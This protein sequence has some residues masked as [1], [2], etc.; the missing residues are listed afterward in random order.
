MIWSLDFSEILARNNIRYVLFSRY[1]SILFGNN[2][3]SE[4]KEEERILIS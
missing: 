4:E 2:E 1:V 3:T